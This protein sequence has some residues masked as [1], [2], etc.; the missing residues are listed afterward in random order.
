[1]IRAQKI[2]VAFRIL[3]HDD[4]NLKGLLARALLGRRRIDRRVIALD[5]VSIEISEGERVGLVGRNGAGKTTLLRVLAGVLPPTSGKVELSPNTL[6]LLGDSAAALNPEIS[7]RDNLLELLLI[8]GLQMK[9]ARR[10]LD[11]TSHIVDIGE[12]IWDPVY[13]YSA[14]MQ[15]RLRL[16]ALF[17]LE[18]QAIILDESIGLADQSFNSKNVDRL[19]NLIYQSSV[20]VIASHSPELLL[21]YCTRG[22]F[23]ENGRVVLDGQIRD[24]LDVYQASL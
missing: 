4:Y 6:N 15:A 23:L 3:R 16:A 8:N 22:V 10:R 5:Q 11:E 12:R 21:R 17:Q 1:M 18:P 13:T 9:E 19:N 14:G 2:S 24:V 20:V 7:G